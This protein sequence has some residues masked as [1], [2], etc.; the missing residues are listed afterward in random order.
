M[1]HNLF[2]D[3]DCNTFR[4]KQFYFQFFIANTKLSMASKSLTS[5]P[6]L[7]KM[8]YD[9]IQRYKA[10]YLAKQAA[11]VK[12]QAE[13][14]TNAPALKPM[15]EKNNGK[16]TSVD[17]AESLIVHCSASSGEVTKLQSEDPLSESSSSSS[18]EIL[19]KNPNSNKPQNP[20]AETINERLSHL[21]IRD[22]FQF[23]AVDADGNCLFRALR[24]G[25]Q[26]A[27]DPKGDNFASLKINILAT[28]ASK[29]DY[30]AEFITEADCKQPDHP[31]LNPADRIEAYIKYM[32]GKN[33]WG[34]HREIEAFAMHY[35]IG[36]VVYNE[37]FRNKQGYV[38]YVVNYTKKGRNIFLSYDGVNHY[39][40]LVRKQNPK[41][42][43]HQ[44]NLKPKKLNSK[45]IK[46]KKVKNKINNKKNNQ[47]KQKKLPA[48][49]KHLVVIK[50][51]RKKFQ[52]SNK[53]VTAVRWKYKKKQQIKKKQQPD[54]QTDH[55]LEGEWHTNPFKEWPKLKEEPTPLSPF[56][57]EI[58]CDFNSPVEIMDVLLEDKWLAD[59][60][61]HTNANALEKRDKWTDVTTPELKQFLGLVLAT[62]LVRISALKDYY[63]T[64]FL[65][66]QI[67]LFSQTMTLTRFTDL[68]ALIHFG[69]TG[70][71]KLIKINS[72]NEHLQEL[73][74]KL[75]VVGPMCLDEQMCPHKGKLS[76]KQYN[77]SKRHSYGLKLFL[78]TDRARLP[79]KI[80]VYSGKKQGKSTSTKDLVYD[81]VS[82]YENQHLFI[83]NWFTSVALAEELLQKK[84]IRITG[85]IQANRVGLPGA[86]KKM[87]D[88]G[89]PLE[90]VEKHNA[91][92]VCVSA[93][94]DKKVVRF[95]TT[96]G[97]TGTNRKNKPRVRDAYNRSMG[98]VDNIDSISHLHFLQRKGY[99]WHRKIFF[100]I[101]SVLL[102]SG[103]SI[104]NMFG[105]GTIGMKA[106]YRELILSYTQYVP[107]PEK[108]DLNGG[109]WPK[110]STGAI[111][112]PPVRR[113]CR[114][115]K[116]DNGKTRPNTKFY[117]S[118][119]EKLPALCI[120]HFE[121]YHSDVAKYKPQRLRLVCAKKKVE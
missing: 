76:F 54:A 19:K 39:G 115:C 109:H 85:T 1:T 51:Q 63:N 4:L 110:Q 43:N 47:K 65:P 30:F 22:S 34:G 60:C 29:P 69:H 31:S 3:S 68:F 108:V 106:F 105:A 5:K 14:N 89:Q 94:R 87:K 50:P 9:D 73:S 38:S 107:A 92:G 18:I 80:E 24:S 71:G 36:V 77:K 23:H 37:K 116:I 35:N 121:K 98:F 16:A 117:C 119:C 70:T 45:K 10:D 75:V 57:P 86:V 64:E 102:V 12:P 104:R 91:N 20:K 84:N 96:A 97:Y 78:L 26:H 27:K 59:I 62:G 83:D 32:S 103:F 81:L 99:R 49:K 6:K 72:I 111:G 82:E 28:I 67:P 40:L 120:E 55:F 52:N 41:P 95:I 100:H 53:N 48:A 56:K 2:F 11:K 118:G 74:K 61:T 17:S 33:R 7:L 112:M 42:Y 88:K 15:P 58:K 13:P 66:L 101:F 113:L 114:V 90:F 79:H 46:N 44:Q 8:K 93:F 25:M 21:Q